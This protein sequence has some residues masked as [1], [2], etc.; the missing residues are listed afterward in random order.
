MSQNPHPFP[1]IHPGGFRARIDGTPRGFTPGGDEPVR[2]ELEEAEAP[3]GAGVV[4]RFRYRLSGEGHLTLDGDREDL[5]WLGFDAV[6]GATTEVRLSEFD[7]AT[8]SN[9]LVERPRGAEDFAAGFGCVGP[10]LAWEDGGRA[11]LVAYEHGSEASDPFLRFR[12]SKGGAVAL[13]AVKGNHVANQDLGKRPLVSP[14]FHAAEVEGTLDDLADAYRAFLLDGQAADPA[15]RAPRVFYNTWGLQERARH[16]QGLPYLAPMNEERIVEEVGLA[17]ELGVETFVIDTGWYEKTGDW[18]V[19]EERFPRGLGP[20]REALEQH[21]MELG[22]WFDP[23]IAGHTSDMF[24]ENR[25]LAMTRGGQMPPTRE[26]WETEAAHAMCLCSDYADLFADE[27]IRLHRETGV[28]YFKWDAIGQYGCDS[29]DHDHGGPGDTPEHRSAC[30]GYQL[31]LRMV[32]VVERLARECPGVT[33]DFDVTEGGRAFGLAFLSVGKYFLINNGPYYFNFD[34]P[35]PVDRGGLRNN[36][37]FFSP[38]LARS[39]VCRSAV[40]L[41]R[42]LPSVLT[43]VHYLPDDRNLNRHMEHAWGIQGHEAEQVQLD[44]V[45]SLALGHG[46]IWGDLS[47]VSPEGRRRFERWLGWWKQV[48]GDATAAAPRVSGPVGGT[49]EVHEKVHPETGRGVICLFS[50]SAGRFEY[51]TRGRVVEEHAAAGGVSVERRE[52]GGAVLTWACE[53][54]GAAMV[55]FGAAGDADGPASDDAAA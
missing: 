5:T 20:V 13:E 11:R 2:L 27:L 29:P 21:G 14:W 48:R 32:Q 15:S 31:P 24:T 55:C 19:S 54:P 47:E 39:R 34:V 30:Y 52:D 46:G 43:L 25:H 35:T 1:W 17:A 18:R 8:H 10:I 37:L 38:G 12:L 22:L 50:P 9:Q 41:D 26:V 3:G 33:V 49:P 44:A 40:G 7:Q 51:A 36:N 6:P 28:T 42:W 4:R 23:V 45:A 53:R 16:W